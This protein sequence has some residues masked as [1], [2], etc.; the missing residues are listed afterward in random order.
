VGHLPWGH[1]R[2][3]LGKI[4]DVDIAL[5]YVSACA[6]HGWTRAILELQIEQS[7]HLRQGQAI[8]NFQ[9][10]LAAPHSHLAQQTL[11]DP[12]VFDFLTLGTHALERDIENQLIGSI[13][14]FLLELGKG[15]AFLG[16]QYPIEI[17]Q[18]NYF[19]D[20]LFYHTRLKCYVIIELKAGEFQPEYIGKMNFYLSAAD[21]LLRSEGDQPSIGLILCKNK[22][23]F[24]VEYA[25][26]DINKP[27]G[28]SSFI[29]QE[30]PSNVQAQLP[31][32]AEIEQ[33]LLQK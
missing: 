12:Y 14:K 30:I 19:F 26:R 8:S 3:I 27:I 32:V 24:D 18:R 31:T 10:V 20:L 9:A 28:I 1:V 17:N 5:F 7:L 11:K 22:D 16:Q 13:K 33:Q 29:T 21:D 23:K 15:F 4:K 2:T 6:E 25:L